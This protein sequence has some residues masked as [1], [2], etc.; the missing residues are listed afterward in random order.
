MAQPVQQI[1]E[2][3]EQPAT[4]PGPTLPTP[5]SPGL[6]PPA[7]DQQ[8]PTVPSSEVSQPPV[9]PL[10]SP[11]A[12]HVRLITSTPGGATA[13]SAEEVE[14]KEEPLTPP[15]PSPPR[16]YLEALAEVERDVQEE[17][18]AL[19][20]EEGEELAEL[21][22]IQRILLLQMQE[23]LSDDEVEERLGAPQEKRPRRG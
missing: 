7:Q 12:G 5:A 21:D 9:S 6:L 11:A 8:G 3:P 20:A 15:E 22:E 23:D 2:S 13:G 4:P 10:S 17:L 18:A 16:G 19:A 1:P 14:V